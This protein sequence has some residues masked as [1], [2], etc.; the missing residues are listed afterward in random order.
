MIT[1]KD[2]A[3]SDPDELQASLGGVDVDYRIM[4]RGDFNS[5]LTVLDA[6][7][8]SLQYGSI[9]STRILRVALPSDWVALEGW[10]GTSPLPIVRGRQLQAGEF[11]FEAPET[12][13]VQRRPPDDDISWVMTSRAHLSGAAAALL[14]FPV[15]LRS[16]RVFRPAANAARR[17]A[18]LSERAREITR[19]PAGIRAATQA[20]CGFTEEVTRAL[21]GC[22]AGD[23]AG[24]G[25]EFTGRRTRIVSKFLE[26]I[27][28][29]LEEPVYLT[30]V[31]RTLGVSART[32]RGCCQ[33]ALSMSPHRFLT[34]RRL[35]LARRAL[36]C[37]DPSTTSVTRI[38]TDLGFWEL[39]RFSVTYRTAFGESPSATLKRHQV[40]KTPFRLL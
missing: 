16:S 14:N 20:A 13:S 35:R 3:F 19:M 33:E 9:N 6:W 27:E 1:I 37:G 23:N 7:P 26:A 10:M 8:V 21:L 4:D 2:K 11:T 24:G 36:S 12:E 5:H 31:C 34:L 29:G 28:A 18:S 38:A 40:E 15:D 39:G 25:P 17:F 32:L 30:D 22:L